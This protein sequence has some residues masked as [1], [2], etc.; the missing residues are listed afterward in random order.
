MFCLFLTWQKVFLSDCKSNI[1]VSHHYTM[2]MCHD[3]FSGAEHAGYSQFFTITNNVFQTIL[4]RKSLSSY[5]QRI[6]S[7]KVDYV[8][9]KRNIFKTL[10]LYRQFAFQKNGDQSTPSS[11]FVVV[12]PSPVVGTIFFLSWQ[13]NK[14]KMVPHFWN[15][16]FLAYQEG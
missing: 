14:L 9:E 15:L 8:S 6:E 3:C 4:G 12:K 13:V 7:Q 5:Q 11:G 10:V 1:C 2:W 16:Y